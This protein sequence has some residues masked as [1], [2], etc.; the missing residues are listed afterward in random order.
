MAQLDHQLGIVDEVTYGTAV[1]VTKFFE[2]NSESIEETAGRTEGNPMRAGFTLRNDRFTP[3]FSGA[4]RSIELDVMTKGFGYWLKHMTGAVATT[5]PA[6]TVVYTHTGTFGDL[7]GD[8]FTC[9]VN[10]PFHPAG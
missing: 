4:A 3:Y 8:F 5:G 7:L 10:R 9:Q 6:E 1:T 2:Y